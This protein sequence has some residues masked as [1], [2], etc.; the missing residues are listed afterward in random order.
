MKCYPADFSVIFLSLFYWVLSSPYF[1]AST[2]IV[3]LLLPQIL[4]VNT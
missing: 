1:S 2:H 4:R 3:Y